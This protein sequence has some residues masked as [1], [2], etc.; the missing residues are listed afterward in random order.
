MLTCRAVDF[1]LNL[2]EVIHA[3]IS[4]FRKQLRR[5]IY[6][7]KEQAMDKKLTLLIWVGVILLLSGCGR[8]AAGTIS[9]QVIE[10]DGPVNTAYALLIR[11]PDESAARETPSEECQN[12][13]VQVITT[14]SSQAEICNLQL[15]ASSTGQ[16]G[17][18]SFADMEPGW[19]RLWLSW[20]TTGYAEK[21]QGY[22]A[23]Q[24][25]KGF[26][27]VYT[28]Q[29]SSP[30]QVVERFS[31]LAQGEAFYLSENKGV[32]IILDMRDK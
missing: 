3:T 4:N 26:T 19:Y 29:D 1:T 27:I 10:L 18:F 13:L 7:V 16:E 30:G 25:Q 2:A 32:N 28:A 31:V 8:V 23:F 20:D 11:Y 17:D 21:R 6:A 12:D 15:M 9:G 14:R 5:Q 24:Q 22:F